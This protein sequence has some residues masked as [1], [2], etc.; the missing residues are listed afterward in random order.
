M[1]KT[2]PEPAA[3]PERRLIDKRAVAGLAGGVST[4]TV[5]RW[6]AD[7]V[8]PKPVKI[9]HL[10]RWWSDEIEAALAK[11]P[12][13]DQPSAQPYVL[14]ERR[15]RARAKAKAKAEAERAVVD[16]KRHE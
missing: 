3:S 10:V 14:I 5:S 15:A 7:D 16:S 8:L 6:A 9:G 13:T 1:T 2:K 12:R 11:L 4:A